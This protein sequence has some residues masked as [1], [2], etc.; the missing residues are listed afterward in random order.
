M[1]D[2][3]SAV[4]IA[5]DVAKTADLG[6]RAKALIA[7]GDAARG[8]TGELKARALYTEAADA[9]R[10]AKDR[11]TELDALT[12]LAAAAIRAGD[13]PVWAEYRRILAAAKSP[14]ELAPIVKWDF[15]A[16]VAADDHVLTIQTA[17]T[18]PWANLLLS[19]GCRTFS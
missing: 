7:W 12:R 17:D 13:P 16:A 9:A 14:C 5:Q 19:V 1:G 4:Q 15:Y 18:Q 10:S 3:G 6:L 8:S 2:A 11:A